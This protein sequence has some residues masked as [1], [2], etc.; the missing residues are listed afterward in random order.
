M[1][2]RLRCGHSS[3]VSYRVLTTPPLGLLSN[4]TVLPGFARHVFASPWVSLLYTAANTVLQ[5]I[6]CL[7]VYIRLFSMVTEADVLPG[8]VWRMDLYKMPTGF[9]IGRCSCIDALFAQSA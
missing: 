6:F 4:W 5:G 8:L 1:W 7:G 3:V 9:C 2:P